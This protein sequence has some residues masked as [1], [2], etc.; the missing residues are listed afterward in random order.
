[1]SLH[2]GV[3]FGLCALTSLAHAEAG[4]PGRASNVGRA[5]DELQLQARPLWGAGTPATSGWIPYLVNVSNRG[6]RTLLGTVQLQSRPNTDQETPHVF[7][8]RAFSVAPGSVEHLE[9]PIHDAAVAD[10]Q[11][12]AF[13]QNGKPI[14]L[15]AANTSTPSEPLLIDFDEPST[16]GPQIVGRQ[17]NTRFVPSS[18]VHFSSPALAVGKLERDLLDDRLLLPRWPSGYS[19]VTLALLKSSELAGLAGEPLKALTGWL[20]SGGTLAV[21]VN[22][23]DDLRATPLVELAGGQLEEQPFDSSEL[24][25]APAAAGR[26]GKSSTAKPAGPT[27]EVRED[28]VSHVGGNLRSTPW[29]SAASYGLGELHVLSFDPTLEHH[30]QDAWVQRQMLSL[31]SYAWD[32]NAQLV[33]PLGANSFEDQVPNQLRDLLD[34]SQASMW[35]IVVAGFL[36]VGYA[37][38]AGPLNFS[39]A[40]RSGHGARALIRVP[41][42]AALASACLV[43]LGLMSKGGSGHAHR[44]TLL[45]MGAGMNR[46]ASVRYRSFFTDAELMT[47]LPTTGQSLLDVLGPRDQMPRSLEITQHGAKISGLRHPPWQTVFVREDGLL[48]LGNGVALV[49]DQGKLGLVNRSGHDLI[50]A[51]LHVPGGDLRFFP[52]IV[53]NAKVWATDGELVRVATGG[54]SHRIHD[55]DVTDL[56]YRLERVA[57]GAARA[58]ITLQGLTHRAVDWW[59]TDVPV[60]LAQVDIPAGGRD[61]N[62]AVKDNRLLI[63]VVGYGGQP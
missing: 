51:L 22:R 47:I 42:L 34:P 57:P 24:L 14:G 5:G 12:A 10:L 19:T 39:L 31:A 52:R 6:T 17:L 60:L 21:V 2:W 41:V 1:M 30:A 18:F 55:L 23:P 16:I 40:R 15:V 36:L 54:A 3:G 53:R 61:A 63:R 59:P 28:L 11:L 7:A 58:W 26:P 9:I 62:L 13:D 46:G 37:L 25:K 49:R 48:T 44:L 43:L 8:E 45:E 50:A 29:G 35:T 4:D 38:I 56:R 32:R 27:T 33:F 20:L